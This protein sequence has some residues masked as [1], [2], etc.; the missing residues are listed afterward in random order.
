MR[1]P[2]ERLVP[3][4]SLL[5]ALWC[6]SVYTVLG[7]LGFYSHL[8]VYDLR[9]PTHAGTMPLFSLLRPGEL[10]TALSALLHMYIHVKLCACACGIVIGPSCTARCMTCIV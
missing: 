3:Q 1:W 5:E 9:R 10:Y 2:K 6:A 8:H 7:A 4:C